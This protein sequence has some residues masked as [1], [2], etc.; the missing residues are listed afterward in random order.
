MV[1]DI[2]RL[3]S[4]LSYNFFVYLNIFRYIINFFRKSTVYSSHI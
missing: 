1:L 3:N 4:T 2:I